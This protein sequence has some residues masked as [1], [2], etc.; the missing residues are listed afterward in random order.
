MKGLAFRLTHMEHHKGFSPALCFLS[1]V[2]AAPTRPAEQLSPVAF[3]SA[4]LWPVLL[5]SFQYCLLTFTHLNKLL[6]GETIW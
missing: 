1:A 3:L 5:T 2:K 4:L 6:T